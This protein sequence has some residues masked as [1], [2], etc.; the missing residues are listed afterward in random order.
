MSEPAEY[1]PDP[2]FIDSLRESRVILVIWLSCF[3]WTLTVCLTLGYS[4]NV[5]PDQFPQVLGLPAWIA[6]GVALPWLLANIATVIFCLGYMKDADL[7]E[8]LADDSDAD[9]SSAGAQHV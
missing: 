7:G 3:V 6:W 2:L 5:I 8:D 9:D 4:T 1:E